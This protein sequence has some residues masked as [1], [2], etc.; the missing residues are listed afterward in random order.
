[1]IGRRA[2][3]NPLGSSPA[4]INVPPIRAGRSTNDFDREI[5]SMCSEFTHVLELSAFAARRV[6]GMVVRAASPVAGDR[7]DYIVVGGGA[8]GCVLA[9]RL[10]EDQSKKVLLLEVWFTV[11]CPVP[12]IRWEILS[13]IVQCF[14]MRGLISGRSRWRCIGD[15]RSCWPHTSL[16]APRARLGPHDQDST[17]TLCPRGTMSLF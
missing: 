2:Q 1:M 9:N 11:V 12:F 17:A 10:S 16:Q 7:F 15:R 8:A 6:G 14:Y 4:T 13:E 5:R 3:T